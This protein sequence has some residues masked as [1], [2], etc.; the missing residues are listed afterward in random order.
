M[1]VSS[2]ILTR[3]ER[4]GRAAVAGQ[5]RIVENRP[6]DLDTIAAAGMA[7]VREP[8]ATCWLWRPLHPAL[9]WRLAGWCGGR[10][11]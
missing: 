11:D 9:R 1:H 3:R 7:G 8:W 5:L 2:D 6:T 10:C 4:Y